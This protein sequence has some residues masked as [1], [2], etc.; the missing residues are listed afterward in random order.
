VIDI[1]T[2]D[3]NSVI[4]EHQRLADEIS[5]LEGKIADIRREQRSYAAAILKHLGIPYIPPIRAT[6]R[7]PRKPKLAVVP[8]PAPPTTL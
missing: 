3:L 7:R 8:P 4:A 2:G 1:D 5:I 6:P